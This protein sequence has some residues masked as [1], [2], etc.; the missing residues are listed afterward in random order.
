MTCQILNENGMYNRNN[1][2]FLLKKS[3][4]LMP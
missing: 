2:N 4:I 3:G 1:R